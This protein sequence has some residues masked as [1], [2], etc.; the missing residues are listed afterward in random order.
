M[1]TSRVRIQ[2][3]VFA[4]LTSI[5]VGLI[6][7]HYVRVPDLVGYRQVEASAV[8]DQGAGIYPQANVTYRGVTVG[9][10]TGVD[11]APNGVK[12]S[13]RVAES[14]EVPEALAATIRSV[15]PIGEQYV[16]LTPRGEGSGM[17]ADGD[18]I[19]KEFTAIPVQIAGVLDDVNGLV[20]SVPLQDLRTALN[21][22][23]AAFNGLG[24]SLR[25][26]STDGKSLVDAADDNYEQTSQLLD[27]GET[28]L[29]TQLETSSE[30]R[31]WTADLAGFS[32]SLRDGNKDFDAM[33]NSLPAAAQQA[34]ATIDVLARQLPMLLA[35]GQVLADLAADYHDP[36]EQ[37]LVY[38]P[39]VMLTNIA[40]TSVHENAQRMAFKAMANYPGSCKEGFPGANDPFGPRGPLELADKASVPTAY[41]D[42]AQSDPRV[43]RGARNLQCFE[44]GSPAG[45][46][47]AS[48]Y[49][50]RGEEDPRAPETGVDESGSTSTSRPAED[51]TPLAYLGGEGV[52]P[53]KE[54]TWQSLLLNPMQK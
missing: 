28:L 54:Q 47:A 35:T 38:Y 19:A 30:I 33:L 46:R 13:F 20:K 32:A 2:L 5:A 25:S 21:E 16:D 1:I 24:P 11:L 34:T 26:L 51:F 53:T 29:D 3:L 45:K 4:T 17:L 50:C 10:V 15:S 7:F 48:I 18:V 40:S 39:R 36:L 8:F 22:A 43:T 44:P 42:I 12:V 49:A 23:D 31:A 37:V 9:K 27:D 6:A 14:A 41:C 52:S